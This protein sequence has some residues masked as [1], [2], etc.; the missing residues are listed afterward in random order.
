M[1]LLNPYCVL[2][3]RYWGYKDQD[4]VSP[5]KVLTVC[6]GDRYEQKLRTVCGMDVSVNVFGGLLRDWSLLPGQRRQEC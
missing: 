1:H 4:S 5:F 2:W 3:A 6:E